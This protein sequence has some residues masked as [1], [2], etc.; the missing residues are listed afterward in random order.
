MSVNKGPRKSNGKI[1]FTGP[2][3]IN[4]DEGTLPNPVKCGTFSHISNSTLTDI[5][6]RGCIS[7]GCNQYSHLIFPPTPPRRRHI[8]ERASDTVLAI[9]LVCLPDPSGR[10]SSQNGE[11]E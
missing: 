8:N 2:E 10:Q 11:Q 4:K 6:G 1:R 5:G 3:G 9:E 7:F